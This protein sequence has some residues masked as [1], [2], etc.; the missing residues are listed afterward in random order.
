MNRWI[1][2]CM[3]AVITLTLCACAADSLEGSY[4]A[5]DGEVIEFKKD[6]TCIAY[7]NRVQLS[8]T[9]WKSES[10]WR[11]RIYSKLLPDVYDEYDVEKDGVKII[12]NGTIYYKQ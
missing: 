12:V 4:L 5:A 9:Y 1:S 8:G 6:G 11:M 7:Y 3:V 10:G 2:I